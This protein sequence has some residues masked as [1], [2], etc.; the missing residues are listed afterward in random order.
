MNS[1]ANG[2]VNMMGE[3]I[4]VLVSADCVTNLT[5][6]DAI[7]FPKITGELCRTLH[8]RNVAKYL[9]LKVRIGD[10]VAL[11]DK[12]SGYSYR[13]RL[14]RSEIHVLGIYDN[15]LQPEYPA[16]RTLL[17]LNHRLLELVGG[18]RRKAVA[19]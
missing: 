5:P 7:K 17:L 2:T 4:K 10:T 1:N 19:A 3:Y 16:D 15:H 12:N 6:N 13:L 18:K 14:G 9:L 11:V 8:M